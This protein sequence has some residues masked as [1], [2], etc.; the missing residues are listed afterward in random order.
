MVSNPFL[1]NAVFSFSYLS[2]FTELFVV[3]YDAQNQSSLSAHVDGTPWS[4]VVAL[5]DASNFTGGGTHFLNTKIT[6]RPSK[7]GTAVLFSGKNLHEGVTVTTGVRYILTGF[8]EYTHDDSSGDHIH[9]NLEASHEAFMKEYDPLCDGYAAKGGVRTGDVI[10]G[11]YCDSEE[12]V[13]RIDET[14]TLQGCMEKW[15]NNT[16]SSKKCSLLIERRRVV[17]D[18]SSKTAEGTSSDNVSA[19]AA[20]VGD[21][22]D[23]D[24]RMIMDLIQQS[25]VFLTVGQYWKFDDMLK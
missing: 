21:D 3:K 17:V 5:N 4:F 16:K 24:N 10:K 2:Y 15:A 13:Q 25:D 23:S 14:N 12:V 7:A 11:V 22:C 19:V 6:C 20:A 9:P 18:M 1:S 8:C